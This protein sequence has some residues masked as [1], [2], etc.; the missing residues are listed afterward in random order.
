MNVDVRFIGIAVIVLVV[1]AGMWMLLGNGAENE[2]APKLVG[3]D[4]LAKDSDVAPTDSSDTSA[5]RPSQSRV[6]RSASA[7]STAIPRPQSRRGA[8]QG[9][10][11]KDGNL[12]GDRKIRGEV[13]WA[14]DD[15]PA[16]GVS[17]TLEY[18]GSLHS[19]PNRQ[20]NFEAIPSAMVQWSTRTTSTG[21]FEFSGIPEGRFALLADRDG[22]AGVGRTSA[23]PESPG[24]VPFVRIEL[25]P[26]GAISGKVVDGSGQPLAGAV[27][28][29]GNQENGRSG[30]HLRPA[31]LL[32]AETDEAGVFA[33]NYLPEGNWTLIA[34]APGQAVTESESVPVGTED[35][36]IVVTPGTTV[37]G[38][39]VSADTGEPVSSFPL[40]MNGAN[41]FAG[42]NKIQATTDEAGQFEFPMVSD[43]GYTVAANDRTRFALG[44]ELAVTVDGGQPV[45]G[46]KMA[47][48]E[49]GVVTGRVYD[50]ATDDPVEGVRIRA[51]GQE[52][53]PKREAT[54]DAEGAYRLEGLGVGQ[55][56]LARRWMKGLTH[57]EHRENQSVSIKL[58]QALQ[59]ID[60]P[61]T[62]CVFV[63]GKVVDSRGNP[64]EGAQVHSSSQ[65]SVE[66]ANEST[67][68]DGTFELY[69]F[70]PGITL[71]TVTASR[72]G[73]ATASVG[74]YTLNEGDIEGIVIEMER[75]ASIAGVVVDQQNKP[76]TDMYVRAA[77]LQGGAET[78]A[79]DSTESDGR[80]KLDGLVAGDYGI[81]L[82][83][84]RSYRRSSGIAAEVSVSD[85]QDVTGI[86]LV[87][88]EAEGLT[89]TGRVL[90]SSG[91]PIEDA[92]V[93]ASGK[94]SH[95]STRSDANGAYEI[96]G[97]EEGLFTVSANHRRYS[98]TDVQDV[99]AGT[100]RLDFRLAGRGIVEGNVIAADTGQPVTNFEM[101]YFNGQVER[102]QPWMLD[103]FTA[104]Y[105]EQGAFSREVEVG[106]GT[107]VA[108]APG[109][110]PAFTSVFDVREGQTVRGVEVRLE[111]GGTVEGTV[112]N[113]AGE[114][115]AG[116]QIHV[117][118]YRRWMRNQAFAATS[119]SDGTFRIES[120][121]FD[122][123]NL[124]VQ[125]SDYAP[126]TVELEI[127]S[128]AVTP[129]HV[130]LD[131]GG[132]LRG[133]VR[134]NGS[135]VAGATVSVSVSQGGG[136]SSAQTDANGAYIMNGLPS[137]EAHVSGHIPVDGGNSRKSHSAVI[138]SGMETEVNFEFKT[139][140]ATLEGK[141]TFDGQPPARANVNVA[142]PGGDGPAQ[143]Y[144]AEVGAD[145]TYR[146][147][148]LPAGTVTISVSFENPD[149]RWGTRRAEA[150]TAAGRVTQL[151]MELNAGAT[152]SGTVSGMAE[153]DQVFVSVVKGHMGITRF[154]QSFW[155]D[156]QHLFVGQARLDQGVYVLDGL[157]DGNYTVIAVNMGSDPQGGAE[158]AQ[159]AS[160]PFS[161]NNG[162]DQQVNVAF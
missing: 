12:V 92:S 91:N 138:E 1:A 71:P 105:D 130:V 107:V 116:A 45:T 100:L 101:T 37:S 157:S 106:D 33:V 9:S 49:G 121:P 153:G 14:A 117:G 102:L 78:S 135:P 152:V 79:G 73:F 119:A 128:G 137:G 13:V 87:Y 94:N 126:A 143:T 162:E 40:L 150:V 118:A 25:R 48:A 96:A 20:S 26:A 51:R 74:P 5:P 8:A 31:T 64:I 11:R 75:G 29:P 114:P 39:V 136:H 57:R 103:N 86:R 148:G 139:G 62:Y 60:F 17:V 18:Q 161:V 2:P 129:V 110:A 67:V 61:V 52:N 147:T 82:R 111:R 24:V 104:Y 53:M 6:R 88:E 77:L 140:N 159:A 85:K 145:G 156:N 112:T 89:I 4:G 149:R 144:G 47:V 155:S 124:A 32:R 98:S 108:R 36:V 34:L 99:E 56:T 83:S 35:L 84:S 123:D 46:L 93:Y 65:E 134:L 27:V 154:D 54:S 19:F 30:M 16:A 113:E 120:L 44:E 15:G 122:T 127:R 58:G 42:R 125:H 22:T 97:L 55:Y 10:D 160:Q 115:V 59:G 158:G 38:I 151:D 43:G 3:L 28:V 21:T 141:L 50:K 81:T 76:L 80:F 109:F 132:M 63:R 131:N 41:A 69:G 146:I 72:R 133:I 68:E 142:V 90:D 23:V 70:S 7:P 95:G 66:S